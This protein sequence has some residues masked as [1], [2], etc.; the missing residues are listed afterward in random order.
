MNQFVKEETT[1]RGLPMAKEDRPK[2]VVKGAKEARK[3]M[4]YASAGGGAL[5]PHDLIGRKLREF[6]DQA[7]AEPVP[8]RFTALLDQLERE[9]SGKKPS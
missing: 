4:S 8:D 9:S 5:A 7:A 3:T 2:P 6:Y 1:A